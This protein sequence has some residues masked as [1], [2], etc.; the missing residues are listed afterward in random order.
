MNWSLG[1]LGKIALLVAMGV[2]VTVAGIWAVLQAGLLLGYAGPFFG[3]LL[4]GYSAFYLRS[5]F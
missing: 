5:L 2:T 3:V 1:P 4:V